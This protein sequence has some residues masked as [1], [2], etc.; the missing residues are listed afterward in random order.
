LEPRGRAGQVHRER[1]ERHDRAGDERG[2]LVPV[3]SPAEERT[4]FVSPVAMRLAVRRRVERAGAAV[5]EPPPR[6]REARGRRRD[7][8]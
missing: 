4:V 2:G 1:R 3:F 7:V 8:V 5:A 6:R